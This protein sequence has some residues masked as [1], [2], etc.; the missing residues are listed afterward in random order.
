MAPLPIDD[1][2]CDLTTLESIE[3]MDADVAPLTLPGI[4]SSPA[5]TSGFKSSPLNLESMTPNRNSIRA[6]VNKRKKRS[7][8]E[9]KKLVN[10][11]F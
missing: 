9:S 8:S 2:V 6:D 4:V 10:M 7:Q 11:S 5:P 3:Q 1:L